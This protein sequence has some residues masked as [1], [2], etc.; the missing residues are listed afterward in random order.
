M[1]KLVSICIIVCL[2]ALAIPER[3]MASRPVDY[4]LTGCVMDGM[5]FS[6][7]PGEATAGA[8]PELRA[9]FLRVKPP[10]TNLTPYEGKKIQVRG[11][12]TPGDI[13]RPKLETLT[14]LGVC[15]LRAQQA[16]KQVLPEAYRTKAEEKADQGDWIN[17]GHYI[18]KAI[19]LDSSDCSLFLSR[20]KFYQKQGKI[21]EAVRDAQQAVQLGCVRYPDFTFL[22]ELLERVDKKSEAIAAYEQALAVCQYQP[23]KESLE[24]NINRLKSSAL[25][26]PAQPDGR[27]QGTEKASTT[28]ESGTLPPPPPLP[29]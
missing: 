1:K 16:V 24:R 5:L 19:T 22:G 29:D 18:D 26:G 11:S 3:L 6:L 23:D 14:I 15:D 17:A 4:L 20:A 12:L 13:F 21:Q 2:V 7:K 27:A 8:A 10:T 9:Y 25:T 28:R